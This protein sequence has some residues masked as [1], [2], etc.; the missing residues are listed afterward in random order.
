MMG[1]VT[2]WESI[3]GQTSRVV[4]DGG[5]DSDYLG[6]YIGSDF[7]SSNGC[8][9]DSEYWGIYIGLDYQSSNGCIGIDTHSDEIVMYHGGIDT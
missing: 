7:Q 5:G 2:I 1:I 9:G 8:V 6:I 4:M 3:Q